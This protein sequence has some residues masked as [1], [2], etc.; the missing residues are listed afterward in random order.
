M[1]R[2]V[3]IVFLSISS[4]FLFAFSA[5]CSDL[6]IKAYNGKTLEPIGQKRVAHE[7]TRVLFETSDVVVY[8]F[9]TPEYPDY[10]QSAVR[11]SHRFFA[12]NGN[13][14]TNLIGKNVLWG[15]REYEIEDYPT[16]PSV[17]QL[18]VDLIASGN[19]ACK[20]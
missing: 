9:P 14:R 10:T 18:L 19:E 3:T 5:V 11:I 12:L 17:V 16:D 13:G 20:N 6:A 1:I 2:V 7:M 8:C 4:Y 15:N